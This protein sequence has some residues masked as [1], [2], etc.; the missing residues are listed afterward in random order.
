MDT[1]NVR[2]LASD[3]IEFNPHGRRRVVG[4][5]FEMASKQDLSSDFLGPPEEF[6]HPVGRHAFLDAVVPCPSLIARRWLI[7][8]AAQ[9]EKRQDQ[10]KEQDA[11]GA[12]H[13]SPHACGEH[14]TQ[15]GR[16]GC[17][18]AKLA[19]AMQSISA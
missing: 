13:A 9:H 12:H 14:L 11:I 16:F 19:G 2:L 15:C 10:T 18:A 7:A 6:L 8:P 17:V 4:P 3:A 5:L 1:Y